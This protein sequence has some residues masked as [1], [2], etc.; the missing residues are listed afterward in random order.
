MRSLGTHSCVEGDVR[1]W[2]VSMILRLLPSKEF[3]DCKKTSVTV[4]S[5]VLPKPTKKNQFP[6]LHKLV[7]SI[8]V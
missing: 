6:K 8:A 2:L 7:N 3:Y 4:S 5:I 1:L